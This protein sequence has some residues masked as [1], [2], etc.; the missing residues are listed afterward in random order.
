M[1]AA[2]ALR[3]APDPLLLLMT[4]TTRPSMRPC[5]QASMMA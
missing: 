5:A 1:P 4:A 2:V 3:N